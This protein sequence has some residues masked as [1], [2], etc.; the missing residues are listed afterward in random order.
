VMIGMEM[1]DLDACERVAETLGGTPV[2]A[3]DKHDM[4]ELVSILRASDRILSSRYH[5]IVTSMPA[6]IPS[7]AS[8]WTSGFAT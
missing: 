1:L 6:G 3:S 4:Y 7:A 2:F 8:R 5:A